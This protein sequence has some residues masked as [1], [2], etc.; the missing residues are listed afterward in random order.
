[1]IERGAALV[2]TTS[3]DVRYLRQRVAQLSLSAP[4]R[5]VQPR[6]DNI[7]GGVRLVFEAE[8]AGDRAI[9]QRVVR[10]QAREIAK[11]CG[12]VLAAG[13]MERR[14]AARRIVSGGGGFARFI[15]AERKHAGGEGQAKR[16]RRRQV[17][18]HETASQSRREA[19]ARRETAEARK[20]AE[21][22]GQAQRRQDTKRRR[23]AAD[24][25]ATGSAPRSD[26]ARSKRVR[27][28]LDARALRRYRVRRRKRRRA[29]FSTAM[30]NVAFVECNLR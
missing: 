28:C 30:R 21:R 13:G 17:R 27:A 10:E 14:A 9:V 26:R 20:R 19:R 25:S 3:D 2:F 7:Q 12:M 1:M 4:L 5:T 22:L 29:L 6:F 24:S 15:R 18:Q 23:E 8:T 11:T 16:I